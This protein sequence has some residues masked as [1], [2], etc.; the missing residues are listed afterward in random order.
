MLTSN[1][2][3]LDDMIPPEDYYQ[4]SSIQWRWALD[5]LERNPVDE[6]MMVL[7][8]GCG[9]G[10]TSWF[11]ASHFNN[12]SVLGIDCSQKSIDFCNFQFPKYGYPNLSFEVKDACRLQGYEV[13]DR[14]FSFFSMHWLHD[15]KSAISGIYN[16]LKTDGKFIMVAPA[17]TIS[18]LSALAKQVQNRD[19][20][21]DYFKD[22]QDPRTYRSQDEYISLLENAGFSI[23]YRL[24]SDE[25]DYFPTLEALKNWCRPVCVQAQSLPTEELREEFLTQMITLLQNYLR[26]VRDGGYLLCYT[27]IEICASK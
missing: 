27:K 15:I 2:F 25:S 6:N 22:F 10:K 14:V 19:E 21:A 17:P 12:T 23:D 5:C 18:N 9:D 11:I 8:L 3:A 20:W 7:D 24:L 1:I 4:N 13:Y 26:P 16:T